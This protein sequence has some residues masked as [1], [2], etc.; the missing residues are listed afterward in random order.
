[1]QLTAHTDYQAAR[2]GSVKTGG[3]HPNRIPHLFQQIL[4]TD[5]LEITSAPNV[6]ITATQKPMLAKNQNAKNRF[7]NN[8]M[9]QMVFFYA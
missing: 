4:Q 7:M 5:R 3:K 8:T 1:M 6:P 9:I 2:F